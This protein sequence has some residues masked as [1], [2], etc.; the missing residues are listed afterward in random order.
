MSREVMVAVKKS[1]L[2]AAWRRYEWVLTFQ[3]QHVCARGYLMHCHSAALWGPSC[4][5]LRVENKMTLCQD[6]FGCK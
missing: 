5:I 2:T 4:I 1:R 3:H 6:A